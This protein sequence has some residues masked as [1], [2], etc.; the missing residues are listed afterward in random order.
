MILATRISLSFMKGCKVA[1]AVE[2]VNFQIKSG[3]SGWNLN[4]EREMRNAEKRNVECRMRN[5]EYGPGFCG[6]DCGMRGVDWVNVE[7]GKRSAK[8][9]I[10][11]FRIPDL[12]IHSEFHISHI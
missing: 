5:A 9:T 11:A 7:R 2:G 8:G 12:R 3:N 6:V 4:A 1:E 10:P